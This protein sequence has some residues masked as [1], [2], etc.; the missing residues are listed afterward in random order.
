MTSRTQYFPIEKEHSIF[1]QCSL[2][3][4]KHIFRHILTPSYLASL[5]QN[6]SGTHH[7]AEALAF[8]RLAILLPIITHYATYL[9]ASRYDDIYWQ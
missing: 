1:R 2:F 3:L 9:G 5:K 7:F 4:P 6:K 8:M